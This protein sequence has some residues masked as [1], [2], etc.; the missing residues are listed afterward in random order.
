MEHQMR[1]M[2]PDGIHTNA[3]GPGSLRRDSNQCGSNCDYCRPSK[4][5][6]I[7][8]DSG[9]VGYI[10]NAW[11]AIG[12][13]PRYLLPFHGVESKDHRGSQSSVNIWFLN[14]PTNIAKPRN[15]ALE[16]TRSLDSFLNAAFCPV[17]AAH[18]GL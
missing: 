3:I 1:A 11:M 5:E 2:G 14:V 4:D 6:T 17:L 15:S 18:R 7:R 10:E 9:A 12:I 16:E 13:P 8:T